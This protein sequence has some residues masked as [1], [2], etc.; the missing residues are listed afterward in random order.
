MRLGGVVRRHLEPAPGLEVDV[1]QLGAA[2]GRCGSAAAPAGGDGAHQRLRIEQG[3]AHPS[4]GVGHRDT[5]ATTT[6]SRRRASAAGM[7]RRRWRG[8]TAAVY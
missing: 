4:G 7:T 6:M 8:F 3:T 1:P 5:A 2:P